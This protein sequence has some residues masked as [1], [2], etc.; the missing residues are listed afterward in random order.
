VKSEMSVLL[1]EDDEND[2]F[3]IQRAFQQA[4]I[5]NPIH[6]VRD[7]QEAV[8]YL[9]GEGKF[10][11]RRIFPLPHLL[12]LDLKMPR[13][14]GLDVL[15]WMHEHPDFKCLPVVVLSSS[16]HQIDVE[17]AY[18]LGANGFVVKPANLER[19]VELAKLLGAFWLDMNTAPIICSGGRDAARR[20]REGLR[21]R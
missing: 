16:A 12:L 10:S 2:V 13:M 1:A 3:F 8:E 14:T 20:M 15:H 6:V 7:G 19:R 18:E 9:S 4:K 17:R 21:Q 5:E 11:D